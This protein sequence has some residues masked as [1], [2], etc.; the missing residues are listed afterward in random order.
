MLNQAVLL[1]AF[2]AASAT[3]EVEE[4]V[5]SQT[6]SCLWTMHS[7]LS[8]DLMEYVTELADW[9]QG[10]EG[11]MEK[12]LEDCKD[13]IQVDSAAAAEVCTPAGTILFTGSANSTSTVALETEV[14]AITGSGNSESA[15]ARGMGMSAIAAAA[16]LVGAVFLL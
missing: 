11:S 12:L 3:A 14:P 4:A 8:E 1:L 5:L 6:E 13:H 10:A 15:A 2:A 9:A 16:G 7:S